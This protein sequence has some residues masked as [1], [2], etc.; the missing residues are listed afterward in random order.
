MCLVYRL[1]ALASI[2][3]QAYRYCISCT[4]DDLLVR[5]YSCTTLVDSTAATPHI[6][7]HIKQ[8]RIVHT[9]SLSL[10]RAPPCMLV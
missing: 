9:C 3:V 5:L 7:I 8:D 6:T 10:A 2:M 1:E 4:K